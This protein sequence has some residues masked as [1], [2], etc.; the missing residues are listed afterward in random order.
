V[1]GVDEEARQRVPEER[2]VLSDHDAHRTALQP[3]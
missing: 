1:A 2:L 3:W